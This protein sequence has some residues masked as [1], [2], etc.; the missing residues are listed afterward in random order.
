MTVQI[1]CFGYISVFLQILGEFHQIMEAIHK[2][3]MVVLAIV[4]LKDC[5][6]GM[7]VKKQV[8]KQVERR[9]KDLEE[10]LMKSINDTCYKQSCSSGLYMHGY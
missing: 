7:S 5:C 2:K 4:L 10:K 6:Y 9:A 8:A 3:I 1:E